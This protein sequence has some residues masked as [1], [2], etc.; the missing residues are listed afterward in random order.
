VLKP[1]EL[2]PDTSHSL[3]GKEFATGLGNPVAIAFSPQSSDSAL[4]YTTYANGGEVRR[5]SAPTS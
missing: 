5:I 1:S 2:T 4:Y 3:A